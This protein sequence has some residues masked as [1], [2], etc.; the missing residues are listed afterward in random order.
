MDDDRDDVR[1]MTYIELGKSRGITTASATRLAFRR[2]WR[3]QG[4]NDGTVRVAVPLD[5]TKPKCDITHDDRDDVAPKTSP[6]VHRLV[7]LEAAIA[8]KDATID[9]LTVRAERA[10]AEADRAI[11]ALQLERDRFEASERRAEQAEAKTTTVL[12]L[13]RE[14][15]DGLT[16]ERAASVAREAEAKQARDDARSA[17]QAAE[18]EV[19]KLRQVADQARAEAAEAL[20]E[21]ARVAEADRPSMVAS[22]IDEVQF[23]RLQEAEQARKSLGRLA[24]LRAAWRGEW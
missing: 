7:A 6:D 13:L 14:A 20:R 4:G 18:A 5:E 9:A 24:R 2:K 19:T 10:E 23:R 8:A 22:K 12:T 1:W 3:R 16:A 15:A 11:A 17:A 21:A